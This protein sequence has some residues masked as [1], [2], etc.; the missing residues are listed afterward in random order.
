MT[1]RVP[2]LTILGCF[3]LVLPLQAATDPCPPHT[4]LRTPEEVLA[5]HRAALAAGDLDAV[6]CNYAAD[7]TVISDGGIDIGREAIK[8][9]LAFFLRIF[10]GVQP[11]VVQEIS[12]SALNSQTH[13]VRLLF[14]IDTPCVIVPDGIDTYVIRNGQ[15]HAQTSHAFPVFQCF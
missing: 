9:S 10:D 6:D 12:I 14:T 1:L 7:A 15:I 13:V 5:D 2:L 8:S 4:R 3:F 11:M